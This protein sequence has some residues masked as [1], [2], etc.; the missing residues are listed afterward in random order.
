MIA[1]GAP[2][3][4]AEGVS[5][6]QGRFTIQPPDIAPPSRRVASD[7]LWVLKPG[8]QLVTARAGGLYPATDGASDLVIRLE[9]E[10]DTS[11]VILSPERQP[12]PGAQVEPWHFRTYQ[13]FDIIPDPVRAILSVTADGDGRVR[14]PAMPRAGFHSLR[15]TT[16]K[17]GTQEMRLDGERTPAAERTIALRP[18]GRIEGRLLADDPEW[19]R[20][21]RLWFATQGE[22][23]PGGWPAEGWA[24]VTTD[25]EGRFVVPAIAEGRLRIDVLADDDAPVLP[26]L[27]DS[28]EVV[29]GETVRLEI[30]MESSVRVR[31]VIRTLDT[32]RPVSGADIAVRYGVGRQGASAASDD[33]GRYE[34][35]VLAGPVYTQVIVIPPAFGDYVQTGAPWDER[36]EVPAVEAVFDLPPI[37]LAPTIEVKGRLVDQEGKPVGKARVSGISE[38]RV[39]GSPTTNDLGEFSMRLPQG[40]QPR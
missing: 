21:V 4:I 40:L 7:T 33:Q 14:M 17:Y 31:G 11:F 18:A 28:A 36:T 30:A 15:A 6:E 32:G 37:R 3:V 22:F 38:N 9:P 1:R 12:V 16:D 34:A 24:E 13:G 2:E 35:S 26:R 19:V 5:D 39:Y 8:R 23:R 29:A 20:G 27:P 10:T 25:G